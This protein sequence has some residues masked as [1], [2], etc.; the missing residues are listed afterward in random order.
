MKRDSMHVSWIGGSYLTKNGSVT[1]SLRMA[2]KFETA[3]QAMDYCVKLGWTPMS[4]NVGSEQKIL[5]AK[6]NK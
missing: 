5:D 2:A 4:R 1:N 6:G 3:D